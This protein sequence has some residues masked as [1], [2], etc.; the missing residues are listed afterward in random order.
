MSSACWEA[1]GR[2]RLG[3]GWMV[4]A[5][6]VRGPGLSLWGG[7]PVAPW[8]CCFCSQ[9]DDGQDRERLTYF[10]NL[11]ESLTSLLV[12]LTTANNP[13]GACRAREGPWGSVS[14]AW[15]AGLGR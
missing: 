9:Q 5:G 7:D 13:D 10:Q 6:W 15:G 12:L 4:P 2:C 1:T 8:S 3:S 14:P 11:P